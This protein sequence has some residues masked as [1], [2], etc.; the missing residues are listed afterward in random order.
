MIKNKFFDLAMRKAGFTAVKKNRLYLLLGQLAAKL[1][2]INWNEV[3]TSAIKEKFL[4]MGRI[5]RSSV[6][7]KYPHLP[8]KPFVLII[9]AVIY[10]INPLDLLPDWIPILGFTDDFGIVMTIYGAFTLEIEQYLIWEKTQLPS[11]Y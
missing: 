8:W 1:Q 5:I 10:F 3:D 2:Q 11:A 6:S 9:A 7:G 4:V